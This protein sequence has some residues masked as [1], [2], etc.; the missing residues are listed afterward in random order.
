MFVLVLLVHF[1]VWQFYP[2]SP[3]LAHL[4]TIFVVF[5]MFVVLCSTPTEKASIWLSGYTALAQVFGIAFSIYLVERAGRRQLVLTS[6]CLVTLSLVGLGGS[7]YLAR[8][9]SFP[10][11]FSDTQCHHQPASVWSGV[12]TYCYDCANIPDCG[13]CGG[14]CIA[15]NFDGPAMGAAQCPSNAPWIYSN[16]PNNYGYMSV[17]FM[18]LYLLS[19]G[20]GMGGLPWTINSEIYPLQHRSLAVSFSTATNWIGNLVVSATFLSISSPS[21]LTAY[22]KSEGKGNG[23]VETETEHSCR[24]D[25]KRTNKPFVY[26]LI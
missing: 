21:A 15:G 19:F 16:C 1:F 3:S 9:T 2:P 6:L 24:R 11:S 7:F 26:Q 4:L 25:D 10:V 12:T 18:V 13:F 23:A 5:Q 20:I 14:A 17:F 8:S 22:G